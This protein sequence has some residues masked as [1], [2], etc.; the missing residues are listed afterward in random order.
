MNCNMAEF[1]NIICSS[2]P[3]LSQIVT[4]PFLVN[5]IMGN[6]FRHEETVQMKYGLIIFIVLWFAAM[7]VAGAYDMQ[8][9]RVPNGG[10]E[11]GWLGQWDWQFTQNVAV[12][13]ADSAD[14]VYCFESTASGTRDLSRPT[15]SV[16]GDAGYLFSLSYKT[17]ADAN[18][19]A[20]FAVIRYYDEF[21]APLGMQDTILMGTTNDTWVD[22]E[23]EL[24]TPAEARFAD[25][26]ISIQANGIGRVDNIAVYPE[27]YFALGQN[28]VQN[29]D[30][31]FGDF[32]GWNQAFVQNIVIDSNDTSGPGTHVF[33]A[34][35]NPGQLIHNVV[36]LDPNDILL[37]SA[38]F[39][40][41]AGVDDIG[42]V[43]KIRFYGGGSF[44]GESTL[45]LV[46]TNDT[47][48]NYSMVVDE[49]PEDVETADIFAYIVTPAAKIDEIGVFRRKVLDT[50]SNMYEDYG[51]FETALLGDVPGWF[52]WSGSVNIVNTDS[53]GYGTQCLEMVVPGSGNV[54]GGT[55]P[56][57]E[58]DVISLHLDYKTLAGFTDGGDSYAFVRFY[59]NASGFL[60]QDSIPL[61]PTNGQ[62][63]TY[64]KDG[65]V[66][67]ADTF[68]I[69]VFITVGYNG[70][71]TG[72]ARIDNVAVY[73]P[74]SFIEP[75]GS[76]VSDLAAAWLDDARS[77]QLL[78]DIVL[79]DFE[80]YT[81][82]Q[83][84][85]NFWACSSG[86]YAIRGAGCT[87]SLLTDPLLAFEGNRALRWAYDNT[88]VVDTESWVEFHKVLAA[89]VDFSQYDE[90]HVNVNRQPGNSQERQ[91]YMKL[92]NGSILET[93]IQAQTNVI[94]EADGS[95][96]SPIGWDTWVI[97]LETDMDYLNGAASIAD[98][99]DVVGFFFG[100]VGD[101]TTGKGAGSIDFDSIVL[102][103]TQ[104]NCDN[105]SSIWDYNQDCIV[106]IRDFAEFGYRWYLGQ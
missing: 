39:K 50:R 62:W 87:V 44:L 30:A 72:T 29:G 31:E 17:V 92:Y 73:P 53:S 11:Q 28:M 103:D 63:R 80:S 10:A 23:L 76:N 21:L 91:F 78:P 49:L 54:V 43:L 24:V 18:D 16:Q 61:A 70:T 59:D 19:A 67:P 69:D 81:T 89:P 14:G 40:T 85:L 47:W 83:D 8:H 104:A 96:Y 58:G 32:S 100:V 5:R 84:I 55:P 77:E 2:R 1:A 64:K 88:N 56:V 51:D 37:V 82:E 12:T 86:S 99:N 75:T 74:G 97:D 3:G 94:L 68:L 42:S 35:A 45:N 36:N 60:G 105:P 102:V 13:G 46:E 48:S 38:D 6:G 33:R 95:S 71:S 66:A 52:W 101:D 57:G 98:V 27:L 26:Y 106:D 93:N 41:P 4:N 79:D 7:C 20:S 25:I 65:I 9:N 15:F 22:Y 90:I 34:T